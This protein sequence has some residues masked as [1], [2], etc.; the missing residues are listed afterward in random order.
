MIFCFDNNATDFIYTEYAPSVN[1]GVSNVSSRDLDLHCKILP[2]SH[3]LLVSARESSLV[4]FG[5]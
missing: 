5:F 4:A 1:Q 2:I 3:I